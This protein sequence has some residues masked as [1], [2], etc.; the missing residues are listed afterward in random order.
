MKKHCVIPDTQVK[1]GVPLDHFTWAGKY[2]AEKKPDVI[3]HIGDFADMHSLS[4]YDIGKRSYEGRTYREDVEVANEAQAMFFAPIR[5][6]Q[7]R[8]K[9]NKNKLW[10][11]KFIITLGNHE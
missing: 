2:I 3:V 4:S 6:E 9:R 11:P 8:L 1:L 5:E 10:N 7:A